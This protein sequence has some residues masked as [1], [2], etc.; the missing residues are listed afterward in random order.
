MVMVMTIVMTVEAY[1]NTL[2]KL[3]PCPFCGSITNDVCLLNV[4]QW[5]VSCSA[6][7]A[8]SG[9]Y[10]TKNSAIEGWNTRAKLI[11]DKEQI[12]DDRQIADMV[13]KLTEVVLLYVNTQSLRQVISNTVIKYLTRNK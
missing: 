7:G 12:L 9:W 10:K 8:E 4:T 2:D 5:A 6:C 3:K 1:I 11:D 13:N